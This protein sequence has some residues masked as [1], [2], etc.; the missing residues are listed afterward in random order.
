MLNGIKNMINRKKEFVEA[1][2]II[3]EDAIDS[4]LDNLILE[5]DDEP[6][7]NTDTEEVSE[8][9]EDAPEDDNDI[10]D[11][12]LEDEEV[13]DPD[14]IEDH[15]MDM[16][17]DDDIGGDD[18][19]DAPINPSGDDEDNDLPT[20]IGKQTGEDLP[21]EQ[22]EMD[23]ILSVTID[24]KSNTMTDVLPKPPANASDAIG[25]DGDDIMNSR[26]DDGFGD[27]DDTPADPS[28]VGNPEMEEDGLGEIDDIM[29]SPMGESSLFFDDDENYFLTEYEDYL[30]EFNDFMESEEIFTEGIGDK[31]KSLWERFKFFIKRIFKKITGIFKKKKNKETV[32]TINDDSDTSSFD[33]IDWSRLSIKVP[34]SKYIISTLHYIIKRLEVEK[35]EE[36]ELNMIGALKNILA[37]VN[38]NMKYIE[39]EEVWIT[40][41]G[42]DVKSYFQSIE[43]MMDKALA[44]IDGINV[45]NQHLQNMVSQLMAQV[46]KIQAPFLKINNEV[47]S[48]KLKH[49]QGTTVESVDDIFDNIVEDAEL[50]YDDDDVFS[51]QITLDDGAGGNDPPGPTATTGP[52]PDSPEAAMGSNEITDDIK[53]AVADKTGEVESQEDIQFDDEPSSGG[54]GGSPAAQ[55]LKKKLDSMQKNM[56]DL[57]AEIDKALNK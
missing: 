26:I 9:G 16:D 48:Y 4:N 12:K 50:V 39:N 21:N 52:A 47:S 1:A 17:D 46:M 40:I 8:E 56:V 35:G 15:S 10:M 42:D 3:F 33:N 43:P 18:V 38:A 54:D 2:E 34:D 6:E 27:D 22:D 20:P 55:A 36:S 23:D 28:N 31:I 30:E 14:Q 7:L 32:D 51:E 25:D 49:Q 41:T 45:K 11:T 13:D 29:D 44:L 19:L 37:T 53:S 24:L 5:A 57:R